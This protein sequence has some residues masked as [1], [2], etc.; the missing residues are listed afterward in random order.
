MFTFNIMHF[1]LSLESLLYASDLTIF[2]S[3][4]VTYIVSAMLLVWIIYCPWFRNFFSSLKG[5]QGTFYSPAAAMFSLAAAFMGS[6]LVANFNANTDAIRDERR[7]SMTYIDFVTH[8]PPFT[9]K[10]LQFEVKRYLQSSLEEEWPLLKEEK[11]SPATEALFQSIFLKTMAIA[12]VLDGTQAGRGLEQILGSWYEARSKRISFR[13]HQIDYVRWWVLFVVAFLLQV[14]VA[15]VH[16]GERK[17]T[18]ATAIGIISALIIAV[19]TPLALTVNH[20][21]G[22][23]QVSKTP[24]NDVYKKLDEQFSGD[25]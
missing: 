16:L 20:Y 25:M 19:I 6:T 12:P 2:M 5:I 9:D 15:A 11:T 21:S 22:L 10:N 24:L 17:R 1:D 14:S 3:I 18:M 13:W 23:M 8:T 7:A 4:F